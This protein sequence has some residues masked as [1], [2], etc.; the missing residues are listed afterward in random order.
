MD[1]RINFPISSKEEI[2]LMYS[3]PK[4]ECSDTYRKFSITCIRLLRRPRS[5]FESAKLLIG[6]SIC[7]PRKLMY[8]SV[9]KI[10]KA[11]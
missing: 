4:F 10:S 6:C 3:S 9:S 5:I 1:T 2:K 8:R 7:S 11:E